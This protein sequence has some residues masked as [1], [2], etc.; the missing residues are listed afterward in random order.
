MPLIVVSALGPDANQAQIWSGE[1]IR[2]TNE[3]K[4]LPHARPAASV[5]RS[6]HRVLADAGHGWLHEE[7][8]DAVLQA[9]KDLL[10]S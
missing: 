4:Q 5:P 10:D 3:R 8:Q 9:I 6:E 1:I 7:R 2:R